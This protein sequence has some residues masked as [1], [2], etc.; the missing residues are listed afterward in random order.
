MSQAVAANIT[1]QKAVARAEG[2]VLHGAIT[3]LVLCWQAS[4]LLQLGLL[5]EHWEEINMYTSRVDFQ[6]PELSSNLKIVTT[7]SHAR[8]QALRKREAAGRKSL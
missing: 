7:Q 8:T 1:R 3:P 2:R 6:P 5:E 4:R